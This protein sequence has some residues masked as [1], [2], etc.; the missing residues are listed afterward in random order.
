[1]EDPKL[2]ELRIVAFP[3]FQIARYVMIGDSKATNV[4]VFIQKVT[5]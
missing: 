5:V 3:K 1:M 4:F 2:F